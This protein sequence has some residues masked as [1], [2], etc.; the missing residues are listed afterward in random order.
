MDY[1][2]L[3][4]GLHPGLL[5]VYKRNASSTGV[6]V[7]QELRGSVEWDCGLAESE[8][9]ARAAQWSP[10]SAR[11]SGLIT[12]ATYFPSLLEGCAGQTLS[13]S[14]LQARVSNVCFGVE[15]S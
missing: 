1:F 5:A 6:K 3:L 12:E 10:N 2:A 11:A 15:S 8:A 7:A 9:R 14:G 4:G 13:A